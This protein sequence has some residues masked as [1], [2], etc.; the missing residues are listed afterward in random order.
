MGN[1]Y[2]EIRSGLTNYLFTCLSAIKND[3]ELKSKHLLVSIL[4]EEALKLIADDGKYNLFASKPLIKAVIKI[5]ENK[6][7]ELKKLNMDNSDL[8]Q[9]IDN[10]I[11]LYNQIVKLLNDSI[12]NI[13]L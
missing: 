9:Q 13:N 8:Q 10:N 11:N 4:G 5:Y 7:S 2:N 3:D 6:I 12:M 1:S